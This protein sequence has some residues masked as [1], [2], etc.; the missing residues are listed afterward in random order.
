MNE[1]EHAGLGMIKLERACS[2]RVMWETCMNEL[3][4]AGLGMIKLER[5]CS[6]RVMWETCMNEQVDDV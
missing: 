1:L 4:H 6:R 3:E 2:R 5:A